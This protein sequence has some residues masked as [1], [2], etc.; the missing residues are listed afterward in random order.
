MSSKKD[1][2]LK[3]MSA[4]SLPPD[5]QK[6]KKKKPKPAVGAAVS[7]VDEDAFDWA[8][9]RRDEDDEDAP[10][11][12]ADEPAV[13]EEVKFRS[14]TWETIRE[15]D[16]SLRRRSPSRSESP[17][18]PP[19]QRG[20]ASPS[21]SPPP[22]PQSR[23]RSRRSPSASTSPPLHSKRRRTSPSP[24][25]PPTSS[26][27]AAPTTRLSDGRAAGLQTGS[28]IRADALRRE[29]DQKALFAKMDHAQSGRHAETVYRDRSGRKVDLAAQKAELAAQRRKREEEEE[30]QMEW[31]KGLAQKRAAEDNAKRIEREAAAPLAVYADDKERNEQ[32]MERDRWGDPMAFMVEK[33]K[34][35]K[36]K[37]RPVYKGPPPPPNRYGIPPGY[38]WDGVDRSNGFEN[39]IVQAKYAKQNLRD[40]AYKW[41]TEDM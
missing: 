24:T 38:R 14:D 6:K 1:Y 12:V 28:A 35:K 3:Y 25:P 27:S 9:S 41:S 23:T 20:R 30:K 16:A 10:V 17:L 40:E 8:A 33:N 5:K 22:P 29:A 36:D 19:R 21:L 11:V 26:T 37:D 39:Q 4:D 32:L 18:P 34:K 13:E 2:L 31:G 7:I 15:G